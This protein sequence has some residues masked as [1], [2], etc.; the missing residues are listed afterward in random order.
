MNRSNWDFSRLASLRGRHDGRRTLI[1]IAILRPEA[2][3]LDLTYVEGTALLDTGATSS[4]IGSGI[5]QA[6][7]LT[8][9]IKLPLMVA[10][11]ERM[12]DYFVFRVGLRPSQQSDFQAPS[13]SYVFA[14][15]FGFKIRDSR[16]FDVILGMDVLKQCDLRLDRSGGWELQFGR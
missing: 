13:L 10:T 12:A 6:L 1:P 14:D 15:T 8:A 2:D 4:G 5:V 11:D 7:G 3:P 16:D 9:R